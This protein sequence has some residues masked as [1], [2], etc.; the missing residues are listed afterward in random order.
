[1][2]DTAARLCRQKAAEKLEET[3][4]LEE[5]T[6]EYLSLT[7]RTIQMLLVR[8]MDEQIPYPNEAMR[9]TRARLQSLW[10]PLPDG[11]DTTEG[12][13]TLRDSLWFLQD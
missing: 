1:M 4:P 12:L 8:R 10:S 2:L 3:F 11:C 7:C 9:A 6:I 13:L 5:K